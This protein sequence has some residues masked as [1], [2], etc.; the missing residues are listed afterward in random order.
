MASHS[1]QER[2]ARDRTTG[3]ATPDPQRAQRRAASAGT[4][5]KVK[6]RQLPRAVAIR[7]GR[8]AAVQRRAHLW[9]VETV[10]SE[11]VCRCVCVSVLAGEQG[12]TALPR[13]S[14]FVSARPPH[15]RGRVYTLCSQVRLFSSKGLS[16]MPLGREC[17]LAGWLAHLVAM[18]CVR[19]SRSSCDKSARAR[20]LIPPVVSLGREGAERVRVSEGTGGDSKLEAQAAR[21]R[22]ILLCLTHTHTHTHTHKP[23]SPK[24]KSHA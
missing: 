24:S 10:N 4:Y 3:G 7:V 21:V 8:V 2:L 16:S 15:G 14:S 11:H 19:L 22:M 20:A 5:V 13:V 17:S 9:P 18:P 23:C 1:Q 12:W 6:E